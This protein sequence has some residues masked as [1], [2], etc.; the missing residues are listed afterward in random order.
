MIAVTVLALEAAE[1]GVDDFVEA[2][3]AQNSARKRNF[4]SV[5]AFVVVV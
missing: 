5:D 1:A 4:A 2:G 3:I